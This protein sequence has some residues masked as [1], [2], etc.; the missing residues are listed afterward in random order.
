MVRLEQIES[1]MR[2]VGPIL[3][4][5]GIVEYPSEK[6]WG[7]QI[8]EET[9]VL[10]DFDEDQGK[11]VISCDVGRPI[12]GDRSQLYELLLRSNYNWNKTGGSK[13]AVDSADGNIVLI[14]D[15]FCG[16]LDGPEFSSTLARFADAA[17]AWRRAISEASRST[18]R[19][20]AKMDPSDFLTIRI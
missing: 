18:D 6:A 12:A 1:L 15:C 14:F 10:I 2:Q 11:L 4:P 5:F 9:S 3:D 13:L 19:S 20:S 7:I 16:N 17:Q 8:D